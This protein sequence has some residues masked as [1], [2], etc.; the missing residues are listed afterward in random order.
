M[1]KIN[2]F[3]IG[4]LSNKASDLHFVSGDPARARIHGELRTIND[5]HLETDFVQEAIYEIM[6]GAA[7]R[8]FEQNDACL[9]Y[10]SDAADDRPRV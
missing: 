9:L 10:T 7:Q 8:T 6:D 1:P 5:E 2:E 3:L 4:A